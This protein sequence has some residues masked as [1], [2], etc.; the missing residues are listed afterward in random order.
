[1][2]HTCSWQGV[3]GR[4]G[5]GAVDGSGF[6]AAPATVD[7]TQEDRRGREDPCS[8][9]QLR[10]ILILTAVQLWAL[11]GYAVASA[12]GL[13][14]ATGWV[15]LLVLAA[16]LAPPMT[17]FA[18]RAIVDRKLPA[19]P[20]GQPRHEHITGLG[21]LALIAAIGAI[22]G[23]AAWATSDTSVNQRIHEQWGAIIV[24]GLAGIFVLSAIVPSFDLHETLQR[25]GKRTSVIVRP[26]GDLLSHVDSLLVFCVAPSVGA[27]LVGRRWRYL[28]LAAYLVPLGVMGYWLP[29]PYGLVPI[30]WALLAAIAI[31]RRWSWIEEDRETAML[32]ARFRGDHLKV[33][34][35]QDL[36]DEALLGFMAMFFLLPLALRQAHEWGQLLNAPVFIIHDIDPN[37]LMHWIQYFGSEL[38][39]AVPFVDWAEIYDVEGSGPIEMHSTVSQHVVFATRVLVDLVFLAALLQVLSTFARNAKQM[40]MFEDGVLDRLDPFI[41]RREFRRLVHREGKTWSRTAAF[42]AFCPVGQYN[43][44][45]LLELRTTLGIEPAVRTAADLLFKRF[46]QNANVAA[47]LHEKLRRLADTTRGNKPDLAA[48]QDV[49]SAI[50]AA[51]PLR[52]LDDLDVARRKLNRFASAKEVRRQVLETICE[53]SDDPNGEDY[54]VRQAA[55]IAALS[56]QM[57]RDTISLH[58]RMAFEALKP[59]YGRRERKAMLAIRRAGATD[60]A[61]MLKSAIAAWVK[62]NPA[63]LPPATDDSEPSE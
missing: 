40:R 57:D 8:P 11:A 21:A 16:A 46:Y 24:F 50:Q 37:Q 13:V 60:P 19:Q 29:A 38:A 23:L 54:L 48:I 14:T 33:G 61:P 39:K 47:D 62:D 36:R 1:M 27:T 3:C 30:A 31:S 15:F 35:D 44:E 42:D 52:Q 7:A 9:E 28:Y 4:W 41:E 45:R 43:L 58:R 59:A 12:Y 51:G 55:L 5:F 56:G 2:D 18:L 20:G 53:A 32:N 17:G 22:I 26:F 49:L 6:E 25:F 63:E 34:F 10:Q